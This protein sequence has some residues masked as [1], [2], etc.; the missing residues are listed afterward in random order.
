MPE[1]TP[2]A[3]RKTLTKFGSD[4]CQTPETFKAWSMNLGHENVATTLNSYLPVTVER[5]M[6]IIRD[7]AFNPAR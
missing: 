5:Q 1:Y 4:I 3:F 2:D 6:Q 7:L